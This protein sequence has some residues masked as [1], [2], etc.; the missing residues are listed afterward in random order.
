MKTETSQH[1]ENWGKVFREFT[2]DVTDD[3][4]VALEAV[5]KRYH[6]S[7]ISEIVKEIDG[8]EKKE[9]ISDKETMTTIHT[10]YGIKGYNRALQDLKQKLTK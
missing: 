5:L 6:S 4:L 8:M 2:V 9:I 1:I 7:I 3:N 10:N